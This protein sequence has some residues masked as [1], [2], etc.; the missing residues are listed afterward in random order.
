MPVGPGLDGQ[1]PD[2]GADFAP[3]SGDVGGIAYSASALLTGSQTV[4]PQGLG[5]GGQEM[6]RRHQQ[7]RQVNH[8]RF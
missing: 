7:L 3:D 4:S 5:I 2:E 8:T 1:T 6:P